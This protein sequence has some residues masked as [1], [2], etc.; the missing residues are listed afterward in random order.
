MSVS[1]YEWSNTAALR[2]IGLSVGTLGVMQENCHIPVL[3][4]FTKC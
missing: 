3:D 2:L 4:L 1:L